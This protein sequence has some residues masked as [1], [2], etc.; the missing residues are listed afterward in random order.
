[1][2]NQLAM[3]RIRRGYRQDLVVRLPAVQHLEH[4]DRP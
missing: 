4:T 3:Q 2:S 1:M